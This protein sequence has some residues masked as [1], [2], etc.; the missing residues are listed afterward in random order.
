MV[1]SATF[2]ALFQC[3]LIQRWYHLSSLSS[4][5]S[6]NL[7]RK[8]FWKSFS[9]I[10]WHMISRLLPPFPTEYLLNSSTP[11]PSPISKP[12]LPSLLPESLCKKFPNWSL[13]SHKPPLSRALVIFSKHK[14]DYFTFLFKCAQGSPKLLKRTLLPAVTGLALQLH[15]VLHSTSPLGLQPY[16]PLLIPHNC[17][18]GPLLRPCVCPLH[19]VSSY[20]YFSTQV[21][22]HLHNDTSPP[23]LD[24]ARLGLY[25]D[26]LKAPSTSAIT[27]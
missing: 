9:L 25:D 4:S 7:I 6:Q 16:S 23:P 21:K 27:G 18:A 11:S 15:L 10:P 24:Q 22:D 12:K 2:S 20:S 13:C 1:P 14:P 3:S 19:L 8:S 26:I 17:Q 5:V